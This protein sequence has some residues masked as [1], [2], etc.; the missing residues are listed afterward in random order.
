MIKAN[1]TGSGLAAQAA[2]NLVGS[3]AN[4]LTAAGSTQATA[5]LVSADVNVV[6]TA[7]SSTGVILP[8]TLSAG[9]FLEV[10]NYGANTIT[11]Y[12]PVGGKI[13]NGTLNAGKTVT[14]N[15]NAIFTCI[16]NLNFFS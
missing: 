4:N 11:V 10:V 9:D 7:A 16:D 13:N 2:I 5:L 15:S 8:S 12:P 14:A 6:T 3:V 1:L